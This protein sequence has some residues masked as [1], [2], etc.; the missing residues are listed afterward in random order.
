MIGCRMTVCNVGTNDI[1]LST[2]ANFKSA[3]AANVIMTA[4]DCVEV[5]H[6]DTAWFQTTPLVAN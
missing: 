6:G 2:N 5:M 4:N 1:T 3:G